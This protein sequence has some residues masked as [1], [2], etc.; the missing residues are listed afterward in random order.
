M[1]FFL[2]GLIT[3]VYATLEQRNIRLY[4]LLIALTILPLTLIDSKPFIFNLLSSLILIYLTGHYL[5]FYLNK[6]LKRNLIIF[7]AFFLLLIVNIIMIFSLNKDI[8]KLAAY[9]LISINILIITKKWPK[10]G[11]D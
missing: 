4:S 2:L 1:I 11:K 3:L 8:I 6:G 5:I 10:K 9:L 7:S